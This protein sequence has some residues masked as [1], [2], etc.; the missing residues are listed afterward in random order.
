MIHHTLECLENVLAF[1]T[2]LI[3][4]F[5]K[6][7]KK[8]RD[9]LQKSMFTYMMK[10]IEGNFAKKQADN[11]YKNYDVIVDLQLILLSS[12]NIAQKSLLPVS[13]Q[14]KGT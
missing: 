3:F 11:L 2:M 12:Y 5:S 9:D 6:I 7:K 14:K 1:R 10:E 4:L 13:S 8:R